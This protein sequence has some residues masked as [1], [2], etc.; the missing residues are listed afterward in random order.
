[1]RIS[2]NTI[3]QSGLTKINTLQ[4]EQIKLQQQIS[5]GRRIGSPSEDPIASARA[6]EISSAQAVNTKFADTRQTAQLKLN[7]LESNLD[8]VTSL[9]VA[10]QSTLVAAGNGA[11]SDQQRGYIATEL[12]GSLEA[13]ISLAN[14]K[15]A[16]GNYLYAGFQTS[17]Q[18]F[19]ASATGA[20]YAGDSNQQLLQV[21]SQRQM[22]VNASGDNV[23]QTAGNDVFATMSN[24]VTLLNTPLTAA[25]QAAFTS[26]LATAM[27]QMQGAT[28][29]VLNVRASVG[30][31]LK[32]ID[33]LDTAGS[34]RALQ[35]S[36]SLSE[37]QDL[38]YASA[39]SDLSKN[40][41]IMEAAQ[42]SF[43]T[44][45]GLSLFKLL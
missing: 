42:K 41:M 38:D 36:K 44:V 35:Y 16:S 45:T 6:L 22:E 24:L 17:T 33:A 19:T 27:S 43:V 10:T 29:N 20:S 5:T 37:L 3:Y 32:E 39:L 9:L 11:Y 21:D 15:D 14:S 28:D 30:S 4:S 31:K 7:T 23:F 40:Q 12:K 2:T 8:S 34:D 26:G 18:P 13:L 25:T 1:M